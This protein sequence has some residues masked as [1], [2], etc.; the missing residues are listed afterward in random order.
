MSFVGALLL[1]NVLFVFL[2]LLFVLFAVGF[3]LY[4]GVVTLVVFA[5][6]V[7]LICIFILMFISIFIFIPSSSSPLLVVPE[8]RA[9]VMIWVAGGNCPSQMSV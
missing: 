7:V 6:L 4:T 5:V 3:F 9:Y 2:S 1:T 8:V